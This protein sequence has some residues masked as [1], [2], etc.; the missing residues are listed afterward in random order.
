MKKNI[1][2]I[3]AIAI[4]LFASAFTSP[5]KAH[6]RGSGDYWFSISGSIASNAV[7]PPA[8]ATFLEQSVTAPTESCTSGS[9][10][11]CV[12]GFTSSQVNP[13]NTLKSG[14]SPDMQSQLKN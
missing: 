5:S 8:D 6:G 9:T 14:Q 10:N 11:Q 7:V 13:N 4:A 3:A 1:L 12:S 2:S